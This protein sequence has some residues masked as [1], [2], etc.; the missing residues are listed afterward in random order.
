MDESFT[1]SPVLL[2]TSLGV[3]ACSLLIIFYQFGRFNSDGFAIAVNNG[4]LAQFGF[5]LQFFANRF[6]ERFF[7]LQ[8]GFSGLFIRHH[9][10]MI[11]YWVS[12]SQIDYL[13]F[14]CSPVSAVGGFTSLGVAVCSPFF[15][16]QL[17]TDH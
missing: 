6:F 15:G 7:R 4:I 1:C 3:A 16:S 17:T 8:G 12:Y 13:S 9:T 14:S 10:T 2:L 5:L 11:S